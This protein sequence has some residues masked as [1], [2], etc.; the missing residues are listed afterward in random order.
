MTLKDCVEACVEAAKSILAKGEELDPVVIFTKEGMPDLPLPLKLKTDE[1]REIS[2]HLIQAFILKLRPDIAVM[3]TDGWMLDVRKK[4]K[5]E[6]KEF[7]KNYQHG[8]AAKSPNR[9]E[10][11]MVDGGAVGERYSVI[12]PYKRE[13]NKII[14]QEPLEMPEGAYMESAFFGSTWEILEGKGKVVH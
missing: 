8:D 2:I 5:E 4:N 7:S 14:F 13:G 3:V 9:I 12:T 10:V 1:D 11:L 6:I